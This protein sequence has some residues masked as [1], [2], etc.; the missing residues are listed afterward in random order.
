MKKKVMVFFSS[1]NAVKFHSELLNYI[2]IPVMDIHVSEKVTVAGWHT[3]L[4]CVCVTPSLN[5]EH[6]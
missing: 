2:D 1:C 3:T 4:C 5:S 6:T